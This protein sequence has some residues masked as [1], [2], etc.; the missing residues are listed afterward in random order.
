MGENTP[1]E[2]VVRQDG[3]VDWADLA[4]FWAS[5]H[6]QTTLFDGVLI[7]WEVRP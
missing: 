5:E 6:E 3:F 2:W 7:R 4:R 1:I